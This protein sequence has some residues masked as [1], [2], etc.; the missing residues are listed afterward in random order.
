M[1]AIKL[2]LVGKKGQHSFRVIVQ[3][4]RTKLQGGTVDDL[5]WFN[6]HSN[7]IK[8]DQERLKHWI[9]NGAQPTESAQKIIDKVGVESGVHS[10]VGRKTPKKKKKDAKAVEA[11]TSVAAEMPTVTVKPK[12]EQPSPEIT[13][14][15]VSE[16]PKNNA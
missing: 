8:L 9:G 11:P 14:P 7:Q 12:D 3:E 6:P 13:E 16:E 10:Y 1:L 15:S 5:G 4:K 2:K